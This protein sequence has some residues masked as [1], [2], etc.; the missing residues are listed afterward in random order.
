MLNGSRLC[1][2]RRTNG[3]A[4]TDDEV[5]NVAT[6]VGSVRER[7]LL[8]RVSESSVLTRIYKRLVT[9]SHRRRLL[10]DDV[11]SQMKR[12]PPFYGSKR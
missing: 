8:E 10:A 2:R 6:S 11:H 4:L 5:F 3:K 12:P 7:A 9:A 1:P